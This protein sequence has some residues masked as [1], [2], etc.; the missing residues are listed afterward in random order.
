MT[1]MLS[2]TELFPDI[3]DTVHQPET[4][5]LCLIITSNSTSVTAAQNAR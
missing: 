1:S 2:E 5:W 3:H 4:Q